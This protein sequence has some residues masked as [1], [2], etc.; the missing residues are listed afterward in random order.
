MKKLLEIFI[1]SLLAIL[2]VQCAQINPL[3]GGPKD[4]FAPQIDTAHSYPKNGTINFHDDYISLKYR[5]YISLNKPTENI[6]ITPQQKIAPEVEVKN[7]KLKLTF[8]EPLSPNTTYTINFNRAVTDI[9]EKNDSIFQVVFS[10]GTFIDS[11]KIAGQIKL[12]RTNRPASNFMVG[13]YP[14]VD[15]IQFDSI[16]YLI[17]PFYMSQTNE[18]GQF[19]MN[20]LKA[21]DYYVFAIDDQNRNLLLNGGESF[22]FLAEAI[23]VGTMD[24]EIHLKAFMPKSKEVK[25]QSTTYEYPGKITFVFNNETSDFKVREL[26]G[27]I[28]LEIDPT[29]TK[30]SLSYWLAQSP[31]PKMQYIF[32][33]AGEQDTIKPLY[34]TKD[35]DNQEQSITVDISLRENYLYAKD[36]LKLLFSEPIQNWNGSSFHFLDKDSVELAGVQPIQLD[37]RTLVFPDLDPKTRY[38]KLD[39]G[40]V[41]S[42]YNRTIQKENW[43]NFELR[44]S[45]YY[46]TLFLNLDASKHSGSMVEL[47]NKKN[48]VVAKRRVQDRLVF[49]ELVP[50]DYQLRLIVDLNGDGQWTTGSL[51]ENRQ[52]EQIIY[53]KELINIKSKWEKEVD[54][55]IENE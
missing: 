4:T 55:I 9:T 21:G 40:A 41:L 52:P 26:A 35:Q 14:K 23:L 48:E 10:T 32:T 6:I 53:N 24:E 28:N 8:K 1:L 37:I 42:F 45:T 30:D 49:T 7:K 13:L 20:Y 46:G 5:E 12:S 33:L 3:Q 16:P 15:T 39:S 22:A 31:R 43:T 47:L 50:G 38:L 29:S 18:Q 11:S 34:K 54:W 19:Q 2:L 27:E 17:K 36:S 44:D 25:I 51:S